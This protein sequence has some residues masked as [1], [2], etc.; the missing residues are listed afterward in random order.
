M[1]ADALARLG[2]AL[3]E[4]QQRRWNLA[5]AVQLVPVRPPPGTSIKGREV[6]VA[7]RD[8]RNLEQKQRDKVAKE[9]M[10]AGEGRM[11]GRPERRD[12]ARAEEGRADP[13]KFVLVVH[14]GDVADRQAAGDQ[15]DGPG[16]AI[17]FAARK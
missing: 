10:S 6:A 9:G 3:R 7:R 13:A 1:D 12:E 14:V 16:M 2:H 5:V 17:A 15:L 4:P 11:S 8:S